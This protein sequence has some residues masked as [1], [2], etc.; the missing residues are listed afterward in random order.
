MKHCLK[1]RRTY[2]I[3]TSFASTSTQ[4]TAVVWGGGPSLVS[5][6]PEMLDRREIIIVI[7]SSFIN[8]ELTCQNL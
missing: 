8:S 5:Q 7:R 1:K 4:Q 6:D 3:S 2:F